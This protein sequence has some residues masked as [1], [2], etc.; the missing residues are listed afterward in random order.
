[1][2]NDMGYYRVVPRDLFNE[3][4]LLKCYGG[5][6]IKLD[7]MGIGGVALVES[8]PGAPFRIVQDPS[9]GSLFVENVNLYVRGKCVHL[10]RPL[11]SREPWPLYVELSDRFDVLPVFDDD[12]NLT[13][14]FEAFV[15]PDHVLYQSHLSADCD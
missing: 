15:S 8:E 1:M 6:Y 7:D 4:N 11:N 13:E 5:L 10:Y 2:S 9:D 14:E 3:S 12:G